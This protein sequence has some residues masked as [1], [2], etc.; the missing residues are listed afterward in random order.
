MDIIQKAMI[1]L[2]QNPEFGGVFYVEFFSLCRRMEGPDVLPPN[3][4][5]A[6]TMRNGRPLLLTNCKL[7]EDMNMTTQQVARG[8]MHEA[9]HILMEHGHRSIGR[10]HDLWNVAGDLAINCMIPGM[11]IGLIPGVGEFAS[12]PRD[13]KA[14]EYY[15]MLPK[16]SNDPKDPD[17][18]P[19]S[20]GF[21][22][23][24][25]GKC[26][27]G[28]KA[29]TEEMTEFDR[30]VIKEAVK[31]AAT[32]AKGR[33]GYG[34]GLEIVINDFLGAGTVDWRAVLKRCVAASINAGRKTTW[35][36]PN[37]RGLPAQGKLRVK[38]AKI[39]VAIDTS[40]S[41]AC[42]QE[43]LRMFAT[44]VQSLMK[45]YNADIQ[46]IECSSE[47][48]RTY[49]MR[50]GSKMDQKVQGGGGGLA[51]PPVYEWLKKN[52]QR[53][54]VL[55]YLTDLMGDF[56]PTEVFRTVWAVPEEYAR[57]GKQEQTYPFGKIVS[58]RRDK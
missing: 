18:D 19:S 33:G 35:L 1:F 45:V 27:C 21:H 32:M 43:L 56:G 31:Q 41:I 8:L 29:A 23:D 57:G 17:G 30:A 11:D 22:G 53:P 9:L 54:D 51:V 55:I 7:L 40:G 26:G 6:V 46:I 14:D 28:S 36:R 15:D 52:K 37:R 49:V 50:P 5:M 58:I 20:G 25:P 38:K 44:E 34:G 12:Y 3:A 4:L 48:E 10:N 16:P 2:C 13:L 47:V 39:V 42:D 24:E